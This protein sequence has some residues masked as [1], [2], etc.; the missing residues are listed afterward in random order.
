L[1]PVLVD[2]GLINFSQSWVTPN[3]Y[4]ALISE[5]GWIGDPLTAVIRDGQ[6]VSFDNRRLDASLELG[7]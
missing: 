2:P 1:N 5:K 4:A 3:E 7:K 6:M